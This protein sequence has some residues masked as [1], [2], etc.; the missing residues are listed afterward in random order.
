MVEIDQ[1]QV[2]LHLGDGARECEEDINLGGQRPDNLRRNGVSKEID[3]ADTE[4]A[5][6]L[7]DVQ[8]RTRKT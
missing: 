6:V 5:L 2:R 4:M 8:T 3:G 1:P 7:V